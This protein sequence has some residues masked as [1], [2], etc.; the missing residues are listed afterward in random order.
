MS[1]QSVSIGRAAG[2]RFAVVTVVAALGFLT[3]GCAPAG[4]YLNPING[5]A[6]F[7]R[8]VLQSSRPVLIE[9]NK[10]PCPTCVIQ[11][12]ELDKLAPEFNDR[13]FFA[14]MTIMEGP[15]VVTAP[16][17][18]DKYEIFWVPTTMLFIKGRP[19]KKWELNHGADEIRQELIK[20]VGPPREPLRPG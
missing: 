5:N 6:D 8:R 14:S 20:H 1:D 7:Q 19:V 17:V 16:E 10:D 4:Q 9:F 12:A 3:V 11:Q 13:V 15:F 18:R 2:L